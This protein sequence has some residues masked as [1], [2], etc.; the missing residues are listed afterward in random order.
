MIWG[1]P[2][3]TGTI[4]GTHIIRTIV[5]WGL[6]WDYLLFGN[7]HFKDVGSVYGLGVFV[8]RE[9]IEYRIMGILL[10]YWAVSSSISLRGAIG[11]G[12]NESRSLN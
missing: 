9:W 1:F 6:F 8:P 7:C 4:L 12:D 11:F 3:I 2:K 10:W 5:F